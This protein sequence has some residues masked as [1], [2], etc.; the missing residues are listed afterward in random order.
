MTGGLFDPRSLTARLALGVSAL[1]FAHILVP[2]AA[3]LAIT[4]GKA[5]L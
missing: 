5:L 1:L 2:G 4:L 3:W